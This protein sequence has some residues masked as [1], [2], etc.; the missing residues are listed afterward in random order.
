MT[1][2]F[3]QGKISLDIVYQIPKVP[4]KDMSS[5]I[6]P[7]G[8]IGMHFVKFLNLSNSGVGVKHEF[9][10]QHSKW[11]YWYRVFLNHW[12]IIDSSSLFIYY[13]FIIVFDC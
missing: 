5:D 6:K 11:A 12:S 1:Q 13:L 3:S 4:N 9:Q 10:L 2:V 8:P 7:I